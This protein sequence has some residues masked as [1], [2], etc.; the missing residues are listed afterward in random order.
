MAEK[1]PTRQ[2]VPRRLKPNQFKRDEQIRIDAG[3]FTDRPRRLFGEMM[4]TPAEI[5]AHA[6]TYRELHAYLQGPIL[7]QAIEDVA[8]ALDQLAV[9]IERQDGAVRDASRLALFASDPD[10]EGPEFGA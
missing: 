5:R 6:E 2:I 9:S 10:E 3:Q 7:T 4:R 8:L 1:R